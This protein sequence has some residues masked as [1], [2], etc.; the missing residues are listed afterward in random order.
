M[1]IFLSLVA[2]VLALGA[3]GE[4]GDCQSRADTLW[5]PGRYTIQYPPGT[6]PQ[7]LARPFQN[8]Y[9]INHSSFRQYAPN[10][11]TSM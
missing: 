2:L 11:Y 8:T 5:V 6:T 9:V 3:S 10:L 1:I 4:D 7:L